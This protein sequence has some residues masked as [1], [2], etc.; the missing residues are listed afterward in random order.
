MGIQWGYNKHLQRWIAMLFAPWNFY[1][2]TYYW[3]KT[4]YVKN[5]LKKEVYMDYSITFVVIGCISDWLSNLPTFL[6]S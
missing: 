2:S 3:L 1:A 5:I 6:L 4:R